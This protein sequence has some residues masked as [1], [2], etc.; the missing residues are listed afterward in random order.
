MGDFG[1]PGLRSSAGARPSPGGRTAA[2]T[3]SGL[4]MRRSAGL[5][6]D[7]RSPWSAS[8]PA[9]AAGVGEVKTVRI[10]SSSPSTVRTR[11]TR[12]VASSE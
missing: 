8:Q 10:G 12:R 2:H 4:R 7:R 6:F 1:G 9:S 5:A 3:P 11:L